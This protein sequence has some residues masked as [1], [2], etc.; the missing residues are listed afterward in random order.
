[1]DLNS[2]SIRYQTTGSMGSNGDTSWPTG[3]LILGLAGV[4][5]LVFSLVPW[6]WEQ[7]STSR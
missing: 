6:P 1:M 5:I 3:L 2:H 4:L 7:F